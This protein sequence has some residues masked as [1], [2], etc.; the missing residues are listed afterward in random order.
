M[1]ES[2]DNLQ[3]ALRTA[4]TTICS[5]W[6]IEIRNTDDIQL[7]Q[8]GENEY[9]ALVPISGR[10]LLDNLLDSQGKLLGIK[11]GIAAELEGFQDDRLLLTLDIE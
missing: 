2:T 7:T 11:N 1:V 4:T 10:V 5:S 3:N 6:D 8:T 9:E